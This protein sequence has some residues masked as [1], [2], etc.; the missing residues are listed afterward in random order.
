MHFLYNFIFLLA[1]PFLILKMLIRSIQAPNY[2][3]GLL[4][5]LGFVISVPKQSIWV[6]AVSVGESVAAKPLVDELIKQ[7]HNVV[8]T[9]MTPTG[10]DQLKL[11]FKDELP[12]QLLPWDLPLVMTHMVKKWQPKM[13]VLMETE[14]W[15]NLIFACKHQSIPCVL[16]NGRMSERSAAGYGKFNGF[17]HKIFSALTLIA[18]QYKNDAQRF[19]ALGAKNV[20]VTG[21]IKSAIKISIDQQEQVVEWRKQFNGRP[22]WLAASTHLGE[23]SAV[24][25][26]HHRLLREYPNALLI[27]VPRHPNRFSSVEKLIKDEGFSYALRS[28]QT[29]PND[30]QSVFLGDT[31]GELMLWYGLSDMA[32]VGNS[33]NSGGGHNP[34]EPAIWSTPILTGPAVFNFQALFDEFVECGGAHIIYDENELGHWLVQWL[35]EPDQ[36]DRS[37]LAA[38][39]EFERQ[40]GSL[41]HLLSSLKPMLS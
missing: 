27:I 37:G 22:I 4:Q 40:K 18:A 25:A 12:V 29:L 19:K 36:R 21:S 17:S 13:V 23:E 6:H 3:K 1:V 41:E 5:R 30:E 33:L 10:L 14:C 38:L 34:L 7:G 9:C 15:P 35:K 32:F 28:K 16:A 2:R 8:L 24:L 31:M 11:Q 39:D 26:A 20:E